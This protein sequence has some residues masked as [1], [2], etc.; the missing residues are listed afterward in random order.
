MKSEGIRPIRHCVEIRN[1]SFV[2]P[3]FVNLLR[4]YDICLVCADV[5]ST[6]PAEADDDYIPPYHHSTDKRTGR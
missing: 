4:E 5:A 6:P 2:T 3:A 1:K